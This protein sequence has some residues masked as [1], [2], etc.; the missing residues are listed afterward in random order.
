MALPHLRAATAAAVT[1]LLGLT[2]CT[3]TTGG[4]DEGGGGGDGGDG[5][6]VE[7]RYLI[8]EQEDADALALIEGRLD[9]FEAQNEGITV[10]LQTAPIDSMRSV[11]QTQLRSGEGPDVFRWGSGPSFGG[12]LIEAGLV[13]DL[14]DAYEQN[15][16]EVYDFAKEQVTVDGKVYAIPGEPET[17]GVFYNKEVLDNLGIAE[18]TSLAEL[19]Q[20]AAAAKAAG[21]VPF[22]VSDQEG[23]QG[24]H[25][26]SMALSSRIG[27]ERVQ[28]LIAAGAL[29]RK[30][31]RGFYTYDG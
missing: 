12:A 31:G 26:L 3:G 11:L 30:A 7:L 22:A 25:L 23:W 16:W 14:T 1:V 2:A 27:S 13:M 9:E 15:G 8:E 17:I 4:T 18:P 20:A 10:N 24:G 5:E 29:G 19:D 6:A 28:A 21:F